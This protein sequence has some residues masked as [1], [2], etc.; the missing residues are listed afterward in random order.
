MP[1]TP[2]D[3]AAHSVGRARALLQ[4]SRASSK[5][6]LPVRVRID[7]RRMSLVMA[8][9][10]LDTYMHRLIVA[11]AYTHRELPGGLA[12]LDLPFEL[13]LAQ[14]DATKTA[15]RAK[16]HNMR[17]R[18]GVKRVLRDRLLRETYQRY[19]DMSRALAMAGR[20]GAWQ[21]IGASMA[22]PLTSVQIRDRLNT[23]VMRRNQIVHEGDY[24]RLDRPQT[25]A[26]NTL[27]YTQASID[28]GFIK[29][30]IDA[31]DVVV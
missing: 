5:N 4:A 3:A 19:D 1:F 7:I 25:N 28:I 18:V 13:L 8:V 14:A 22:P 11:R 20:P 21:E 31:I 6:Q 30:L 2:Y 27:T 15:A 12:K 23:I 10:S 26:R 17:P 24:R 9:S 29:D 16:R